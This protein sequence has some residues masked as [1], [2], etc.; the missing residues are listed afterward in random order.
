MA[1]FTMGGP[2]SLAPTNLANIQTPPEAVQMPAWCINN[3]GKG[4]L[5]TRTEACQIHEATYTTILYTNGVPKTTGVANL[6]IAAYEFSDRKVD[7]WVH[8]F[9][10]AAYSGWGDALKAT[11]EGNATAKGDCTLVKS[12]FPDQPIYQPSGRWAVGQ[13]FFR[14]TAQNDGDI[15]QCTT[16]WNWTYKNP[17]YSTVMKEY[18]ASNIRCDKTNGVVGCVVPWYAAPVYY[19]KTRIPGLA[20]HVERAQASGLPGATS[21]RPLHRL[22]DRTTIGLNRNMACVRG[23][24]PV[25]GY[26]CDEY[27]L[28]S[29]YEGLAY[30]GG[31]RRT[32]S[33]CQIPNVPNETGPVGVSVCMVPPFENRSQ[34]GTMSQFYQAERV[35]DG[36]PYLILITA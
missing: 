29:T 19:S 21:D 28:A 15:G 22:T 27:P 24:T 34:G 14:T 11:V 26:W 25:A 4:I 2:K 35:L 9:E 33:N 23:I 36:D 7:T 13:G 18:S 1:C 10:V 3:A 6:L 16:A 8:Q 31:T 30:T 17:G 32:F 5:G 12:D 20:S